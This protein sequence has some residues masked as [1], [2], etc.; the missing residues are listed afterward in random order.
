MLAENLYPWLYRGEIILG[1]LV[2]VVILFLAIF[3]RKGVL[4]IF[5]WLITITAV[6]LVGIGVAIVL[7]GL[8]ISILTAIALATTGILGSLLTGGLLILGGFAIS[9]LFPGGTQ[10]ITQEIKNRFHKATT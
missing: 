9:L 5:S 7:L 6:A 4:Y 1:I 2:T 3:K 8:A 10:R